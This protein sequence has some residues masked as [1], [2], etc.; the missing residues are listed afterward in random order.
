M[1]ACADSSANLRCAQAPFE[2]ARPQVED[3]H[4]GHQR[5]PQPGDT[6]APVSQHGLLDCAGRHARRQPLQIE[7]E[8]CSFDI[9][10]EISGSDVAQHE[11]LEQIT[12][13]GEEGDQ[14]NTQIAE[15]A[16]L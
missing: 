3:Q 6:R 7:R 13:H 8:M 16:A 1:T 14:N 15:T 2:D 4:S 12:R 11:L 10:Y 5:N 9:R